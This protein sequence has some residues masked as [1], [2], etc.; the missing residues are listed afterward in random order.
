M[1]A[2]HQR[3][4]AERRRVERQKAYVRKIVVELNAYD[5]VIYDICDEPD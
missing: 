3:R 2:V 4:P 5:N 1:L